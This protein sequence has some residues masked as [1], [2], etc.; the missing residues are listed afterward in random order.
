MA[1][2]AVPACEPSEFRSMDPK[3]FGFL[4][5]R[6]KRVFP[7]VH[8]GSSFLIRMAGAGTVA[9]FACKSHHLT[10]GCQQRSRTESVT[11]VLVGKNLRSKRSF[12]S[13]AG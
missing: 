4:M 11:I 7:L 1:S 5:C 9:C 6:T 8:T 3:K 12:R 10:T 2:N 13:V